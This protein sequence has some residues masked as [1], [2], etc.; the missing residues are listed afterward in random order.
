[1]APQAF[2]SLGYQTGILGK[3]HV[4]PLEV[5]PS[6]WA[7]ET[8]RPF[9]LKV[10]LRESHRDETREGFGNDEDEAKDISVPDYRAADVVMPIFIS[11][12]PELRMELVEHYKSISHTDLGV[13]LLLGELAKR[14]LDWSTLAIF[15]SDNGS[16]F[17]NLKT[18]L[19]D[20]GVQLPLLL[21]QP[22][23]KSGVW[24]EGIRN[25]APTDQSDTPEV[26]LGRR[27]LQNHVNRGPVELFD[28]EDNPEE[29]DTLAGRPEF[30][31]LLREV[32][33][34]FEGWQ[35]ETGDPKNSGSVAGP[36]RAPRPAKSSTGLMEFG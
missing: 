9:H 10:G 34:E 8:G 20:V 6:E 27:R 28:L 30:E 1:M 13:G 36:H 18:T 35:Y 16:L 12:V 3:V 24:R 21:W 31:A 33:A 19:Y 11:D 4:G 5:Y 25:A 7:A 15:V 32:R 23:G 29:V 14:G 22:G 26:M 2:N 17:L